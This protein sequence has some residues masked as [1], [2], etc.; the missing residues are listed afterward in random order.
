M[1]FDKTSWNSFNHLIDC[2]VMVAIN[3][4]HMITLSHF[5]AR[6]YMSYEFP[7][8]AESCSSSSSHPMVPDTMSYQSPK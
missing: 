4:I 3:A 8:E 7:K 5:D 1:D 2:S 6:I